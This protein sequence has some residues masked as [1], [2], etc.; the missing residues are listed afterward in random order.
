MQLSAPAQRVLGALVEKAMATPQSYPLSLNALRSATNQ[1]TNREPVVDYD[2]G[3]LRDAL[4]ELAAGDLVTT[5]YA[6]RSNTPKYAHKLGEHLE[7]DDGQVAVLAVLLLRGPQTVG[8]LRQRTDRMHHF[9]ELSGVHRTLEALADHPFG[10][11]ATET[12]RQPGQKEARWRHLLDGSDPD[13]A[14]PPAS[15]AAPSGIDP[16]EVAELRQEVADLR[17]EV[18]VLSDELDRI[19]RF[20]GA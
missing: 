7:I 8:E 17:E 6:A 4:Q 5:V 3:V 1:T 11:L 9:D 15:A 2:E 18:A 13:E 10:V 20:V 14:P 16:T 12:P 19:R